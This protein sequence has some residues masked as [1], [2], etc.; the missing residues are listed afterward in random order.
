MTTVCHLLDATA[1]WEQRLALRALIDRL[2]ADRFRQVVAAIDPASALML[3]WWA[4][5][6]HVLHRL[7]PIDVLAAPALLR[8]VERERVDVIH[9]WGFRAAVA[10][11]TAARLPVVLQLFEP[12]MVVR[13]A[14]LMRTLSHSA[15]LAFVC[16]SGI[17][18][19]RLVECGV[20]F[21]KCVVVR[22]GID[23]SVINRFRRSP[24]RDEL[25]VSREETLA[26]T[27]EVDTRE[28]GAFEAFWG[29]ALVNQ[30]DG[31]WKMV[32][33]G[34]SAERRRIERFAA[35][36]P[37]RPTLVCCGDHPIEELISISD[38]L[39]TAPYGDV[40][41]TAIA[42]AMAAG[43]AVIGSAVPSI[44][45][46]IAHK[47]N[48]LLFKPPP[49]RGAV[50]DIVRQLQ[51]RDSQ[52]KLKEVARGQAYEVFG[53]RRFLDQ[54][55]LVYENMLKGTPVAEGVPDPAVVAS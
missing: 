50:V 46:L 42:W 12:A 27:P 8:F 31:R 18:Q 5:E 23:F 33:P 2:P 7:L 11:R 21:D 48:G 25:S 43:V 1:G 52:S 34:D 51:D 36:L 35:G 4:M 29:A 22:P 49:R 38:V 54:I 6:G 44:A 3:R 24:L 47:V 55:A 39:I 20:A 9:A 26:V 45:E 53:M 16:A 41:T 37:S 10:A 13:H 15:R 17:V 32:V 14:K 28:N 30:L 40:S 19:R